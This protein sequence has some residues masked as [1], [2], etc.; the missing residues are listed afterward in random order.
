MPLQAPFLLNNVPDIFTGTHGWPVA[1][2]PQIVVKVVGELLKKYG[3]ETRFFIRDSQSSVE[4]LIGANSILR[5]NVEIIP[6]A[7]NVL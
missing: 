6:L 2:I 7:E 4:K 5:F 1:I 3:F